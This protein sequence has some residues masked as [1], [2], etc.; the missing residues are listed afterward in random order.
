MFFSTL[1]D[2]ECKFFAL[3]VF[4]CGRRLSKLPSTCPYEHFEKQFSPA[5]SSSQ[6]F[7]ELNV[8]FSESNEISPAGLSKPHYTSPGEQF[9][10][11]VLLFEKDPFFVNLGHWKKNSGLFF[12]F[13]STQ[14]SKLHSISPKDHLGGKEVFFGKKNFF[15]NFG[16]SEIFSSTFVE[17]SS[18][19]LSNL[20]LSCPGKQFEGIIFLR[21]FVFCRYVTLREKC[22]TFCRKKSDGLSKLIFYVSSRTTSDKM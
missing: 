6:S 15:I 19:G 2:F 13:S 3:I 10:E 8:I 1:L 11:E 16:D 14:L 12:E 22:S 9:E 18:A 21:K 20:R 7:S 5:K 17:I 4:F